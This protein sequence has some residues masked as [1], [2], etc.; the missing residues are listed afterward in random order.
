MRF[1]NHK[2]LSTHSFLIIFFTMLL[3][4]IIISRLWISDIYNQSQNELQQLKQ[5]Y[6]KSQKNILKNEVDRIVGNIQNRI[7]LNKKNRTTQEIVKEQKKILNVI[8]KIKFGVDGYIFIYKND[9]TNIMHPIK[10][11]L[12]GKNL[13]NLQDK[14]GKYVIAELIKASKN[15]LHPFVKYLWYQPS[16][17][18]I[19]E[20]LGY[21]RS[22]P[23]W[24]WMIGSGIYMN[25]IDKVILQK[26]LQL[27]EKINNKI[28]QILILFSIMILL[29]SYLLYKQALKINTSFQLFHQFLSKAHID[30]NIIDLNKINFIEFK[31]LANDTNN[32]IIKRTELQKE[33][34]NKNKQMVEQSRLAQMGEMISMIAHQ[35][36]QP[37]S[38]ISATSGAIN[39]KA[40]FNK[41]DN[42]TAIELS[43]KINE[44]AQ[45]LSYT[46]DDFREFFKPN[47]EKKET[48][49][50]KVIQS[51]L[52]IVQTAIENKNIQIIKKYNSDVVF[53]TYPNELKQVVLNL[54]KNA[55]D[56]L[57]DNEIENPTIT[58]TTKENI[59]T[60]SDNAGGV[61]PDIIPKIFDPYFSTKTKKNGTGLGLY[62]SKTIIEEHCGGSL[63]VSNSDEGAVFSIELGES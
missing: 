52:N 32:M 49:Y 3:F 16:T 39:L 44:Y 53:N 21:A 18:K 57:L 50:D 22:V 26:R 11:Q 42:D 15:N 54:I 24:G 61:P 35:W 63:S 56:I 8:R 37:L 45:H 17:K 55:E 58:I 5:N 27:K 43:S 9:G 40:N 34:D 20:K 10:P 47:K 29:V 19:A 14:S 4:T 30:A 36:R 41:L 6:I 13:I 7:S 28:I 51:V 59:L 62:M 33:L 38:A 48:T 46:I 60:I 1:V 23:Q 31:E 2:K 12:E 25:S